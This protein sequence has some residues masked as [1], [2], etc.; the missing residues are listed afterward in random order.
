MTENSKKTTIET[1]EES[2][3]RMNKLENVIYFLTYDTKDN[4]RAA[5]K[6]IYDMVLTL[7]ENGYN[8]KILVE[9][10][11]YTGV[12]GWLGDIYNDIPVVSIKDD[13]AEINLD[14][15][16]VVPEIYSNTLPQLSNIKCIKILLVQQ[17]DYIFDSL[18]IGSKW[19]DF[20]FDRCITTTASA[21]KYINEYFPEAFVYL[22]PPEIGENFVPSELP[23][24]PYIAISC[25][26]RTQ[27]RKIVSE[28][29]L[30]FPH[31]RWITF[32]DMVQQSYDEFSDNL[33]ECMCSVWVDDE[34]TFGT[35]PLESMKCEVTVI[36][37][38][39]HT[40]PDWLG[41]N[42]IWTYDIN[43]VTELLG[44]YVQAWVS[45]ADLSSEVV[46]KMT[47]TPK[48]YNKE[49]REVLTLNVF[50]TLLNQREET[51]KDNIEKL[52]EEK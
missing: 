35:F 38:I 34:S 14:D 12:Q 40:E 32:R 29:Y 11:N 39:P 22:I 6:H 26:D 19:G 46:T 15:T 48:P 37:K 13:R 49:N 51:I 5:I 41:E 7:K 24:K 36:G 44:K 3:G 43:K 23:K 1:L 20:G 16:I 28:F 17:K 30:K 10:K 33:K 45:G 8:A 31:L 25:R 18:P 50:T 47:D 52:K 4:P 2:L 42:G 9:D 21:K 27:H